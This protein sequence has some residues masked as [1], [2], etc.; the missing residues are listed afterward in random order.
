M[1]GTL[2]IALVTILLLLLLLL[3]VMQLFSMYRPHYM[4]EILYNPIQP[5][6]WP[7]NGWQTSSPEAQGMSSSKLLKMIHYYH[8]EQQQKEEIGIDSITIIRNEHIIADFYLNPLF[9]KDTKHIIN[10]CTKSIVGILMGIAI[11]KGF[12]KNVNVPLLTFF[13]HLNIQNTREALKV[14]TIKD[15]LTMRTGWHSQDSYLYQWTGLFKMQITKNWTEYIL[16]L[17]FET[18]PNTRFD[19]SNMASFLLSAIITKASGMDTLSFANKHLFKPLGIKDIHWGKSPEGIYK[20][21]ARMWLKP[22][23]MAKIGLLY[24]QKGKWEGQQIITK[25]WV[26][27]SIKAHSFPKKYR[28]LYKENKKIDFGASG[29]NWV[30]SNLVRPFTDGYGY[31]WWLDQ[32]GIF[33]AIGVGGQYI[34]VTPKEK[35]IVVVTSK[36]KGKETFLPV[37]LLKKFIIPAIESE[38]SIPAN[39]AA[40]KKLRFYSIPPLLPSKSKPLPELPIIAQKIAGKRYMLNDSIHLNPW[41]YDNLSLQFELNQDYAVFSYHQ[42]QNEP[43]KYEVGLNNQYRITEFNNKTYAAIGEWTDTNTFTISY[44]MVGYS[45]NGKWIL[46]FNKDEIE[47]IEMGMTGNYHING[48]IKEINV[49][50]K[51]FI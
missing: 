8:H 46:T 12:I 9:P 43:I 41:Q 44:E 1:V 32:S 10:S 24:L 14:L 37:T 2:L 22:H 50:E 11:E 13:N 34:M 31:Q 27:A 40:Y 7:T 35:L 49:T 30:F 48:I 23:D 28:Y 3:T 39:E 51:S 15:L 26:E 45:S 16:N 38:K 4:K 19:Y 5:K 18:N 17:P 36:L 29:G 25:S 42:L 33:A 6:Y 21:Y 47:V 20:G